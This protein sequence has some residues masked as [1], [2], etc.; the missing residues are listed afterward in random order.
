LMQPGEA[1]VTHRFTETQA[2]APCTRGNS[3]SSAAAQ[4]LS[5][6]PCQPARLRERPVPRRQ[7]CAPGFCTS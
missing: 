3:A 2:L 7:L 4:L 5:W 1:P 6:F